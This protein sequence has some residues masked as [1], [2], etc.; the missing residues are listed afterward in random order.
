MTSTVW[1]YATL[2]EAHALD[3]P[4]DACRARFV[5][6]VIAVL[7]FH[8]GAWALFHLA[9]LMPPPFPTAPTAPWGVPAIISFCFWAGLYGA[10]YGLVLP[11]LEMPGWL[12]GLLLG[13]IAALVLW[14]V[15]APIKGRPIAFGWV[16]QSML[17]VLTIHAVWGIGVGLILPLLRM[18]A[19]QRA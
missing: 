16:P 12:S 18:R 3:G 7:V 1:Q 10:V 8:Q 13:V 4:A 17:V 6:G 11:K 15:V 19:P 2:G 5:A 9:G 14:F